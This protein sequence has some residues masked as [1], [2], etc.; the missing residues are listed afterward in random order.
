MSRKEPCSPLSIPCK[1]R[2][3]RRLRNRTCGPFLCRFPCFFFNRYLCPITESKGHP[4]ILKYCYH[5]YCG[6][7]KLL[8][9]YC[10]QIGILAHALHEHLDFDLLGITLQADVLNF[11]QPVPGLFEAGAVAFIFALVFFLILRLMRI[12]RNGLFYQLCYHVG[13]VLQFPTFCVKVG[14]IGK[15]LDYLVICR[16][17]FCPVMQDGIE[18]GKES[19]FDLRFCKY[20]KKSVFTAKLFLTGFFIDLFHPAI[21]QISDETVMYF[22][23]LNFL[24]IYPALVAH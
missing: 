3:A 8:V 16:H 6:I 17:Y 23:R 22:D 20:P 1:R 13:L 18:G 5:I 19:R 7:P 21:G 10:Y 11:R 2:K 4:L 14:G 12:F 9:K 24:T 15:G